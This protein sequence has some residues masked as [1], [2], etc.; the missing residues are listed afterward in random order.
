M[1]ELQV[2]VI[3]E[4]V[5]SYFL[6]LDYKS[7]LK[8]AEKTLKLREEYLTIIQQKFNGGIIAEIDL[9]Q[10]QMQKAIAESAIPVY[11]RF[12]AKT[13]NALSILIGKKPGNIIADKDLLE[14]IVPSEIPNGLP[15]ELLERRPD[16][17]EAEMNLMAQNAQIG[18]AVAMRFPAIS[19]SGF[20]GGASNDLS[21]LTSGGLV[22]NAGANLLGPIF[23]FGM[24]KARVDIEREKTK[25][26]LYSYNK[27]VLQSFREV[28][29]ALIDIQTYKDE[30]EARKSHFEAAD[31]AQALSKQRYD[32]GVT[33]YLEVLES[34]RQAFEAE[35][36]LYKTK[37]EFLNSYVKLYKAVGGGWI[38]EEE[39]KE[40]ENK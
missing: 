25:Q 9:N 13:E 24:N 5:N 18:V 11:T 23:Q 40:A 26:A 32:Q 12:V 29:D 33:S 8:V 19:L 6:L 1:R 15:S 2:S 30:I 10:A 28:E 14:A 31:N 22:W 37:Q 17:L 38:S 4:V 39:K 3:T 34:Q 36:N 35:L 16:I 20:L 7:R 27:V 21:N